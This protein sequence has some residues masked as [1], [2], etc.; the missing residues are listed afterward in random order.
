MMCICCTDVLQTLEAA[1][2]WAY[3]DLATGDGRDVQGK[4]PICFSGCVGKC[5]RISV[6][7]FTDRFGGLGFRIGEAACPDPYF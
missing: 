5:I 4:G 3:F 6:A 7:R 2:A 1:A